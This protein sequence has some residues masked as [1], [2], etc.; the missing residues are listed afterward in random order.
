MAAFSSVVSMIEPPNALQQRPCAT[1][2][3][4]KL[5]SPQPRAALRLPRARFRSSLWDF[6]LAR[7]A[8]SG[9]E[10]PGSPKPRE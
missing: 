3:D 4:G 6:S 10:R 5:M 1:G 8:C 9:G 7:C 2:A